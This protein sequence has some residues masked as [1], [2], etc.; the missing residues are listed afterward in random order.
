M[1]VIAGTRIAMN[2]LQKYTKKTRRDGGLSF[3]IKDMN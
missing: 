2:N 1:T 3:L